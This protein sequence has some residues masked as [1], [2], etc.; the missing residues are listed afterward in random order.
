M[1]SV[2]FSLCF[3][4]LLVGCT[5]QDERSVSGLKPGPEDP[6]H[7]FCYCQ[8][9][10]Q[11][12]DPGNNMEECMDSLGVAYTRG[13]S[14]CEECFEDDAGYNACASGCSTDANGDIAVFPPLDGC[15]NTVCDAIYQ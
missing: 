5:K 2:F 15:I 6:P 10:C 8:V 9:K 13:M 4:G 12:V 7:Q 11:D 3:I 14:C 1:R